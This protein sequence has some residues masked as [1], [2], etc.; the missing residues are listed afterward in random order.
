[1]TE[2]P[3]PRESGTRWCVTA[4]PTPGTG[5]EFEGATG[6]QFTHCLIWKLAMRK[7]VSIPPDFGRPGYFY[8]PGLPVSSLK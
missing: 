3:P 7:A 4:R 1:L 6:L 8:L 2:H 5:K